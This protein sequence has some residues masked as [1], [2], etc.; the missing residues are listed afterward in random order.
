[1]LLQARQAH[2]G[3]PKHIESLVRRPEIEQVPPIESVKTT[4]I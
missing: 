4:P 1:M 2:K 3:T